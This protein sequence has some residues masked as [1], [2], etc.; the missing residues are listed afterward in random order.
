MRGAAI[1]SACRNSG[2]G[3]RE[4]S[5]GGDIRTHMMAGKEHSVIPSY[6]LSHLKEAAE[7]WRGSVGKMILV[8][9]KGSMGKMYRLARYKTLDPVDHSLAPLP[10]A[11]CLGPPAIR[12]LSPS[13]HQWRV[14]A[15]NSGSTKRKAASLPT[16]PPSCPCVMHVSESKDEVVLV[17][18]QVRQI[19]DPKAGGSTLNH[20]YVIYN[21]TRVS[22]VNPWGRQSGS[23][24]QW[25][26]EV[27][28][29][30]G[31]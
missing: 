11:G 19:W 20:F 17:S 31:S 27:R 28:T 22:P 4:G 7:S 8:L 3:A 1:D 21:P 15:P 9:E 23:T 16:P 14:L 5:T 2:Q 18:P 30:G 24:A 26:T 10:P 12:K 29:W 13:L 6:V 25:Q